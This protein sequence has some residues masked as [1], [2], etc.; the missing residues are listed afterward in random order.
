M[1]PF[2]RVVPGAHVA[3][4]VALPATQ[5]VQLGT[6][7]AAVWVVGGHVMIMRDNGT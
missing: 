6:V 2:V 7:Q 1:L 5:V 4:T 3:H